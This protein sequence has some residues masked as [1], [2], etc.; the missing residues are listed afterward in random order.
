VKNNQSKARQMMA[1]SASIHVFSHSM[2]MDPKAFL[3]KKNNDRP[4]LKKKK[5]RS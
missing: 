5:G 4:W 3:V 2:P 1:L